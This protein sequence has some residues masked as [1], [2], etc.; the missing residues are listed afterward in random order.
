MVGLQGA[1]AG[2][3]WALPN[4]TRGIKTTTLKSQISAEE[5]LNDDDDDDDDNRPKKK[6]E[7]GG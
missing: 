5:S 4:T 7:K 2:P 1:N 3:R 6:K